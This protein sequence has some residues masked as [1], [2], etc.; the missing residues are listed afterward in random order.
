[1]WLM[2]PS[3]DEVASL[4]ASAS[5]CDI[6]APFRPPRHHVTHLRRGSYGVLFEPELVYIAG[7][8]D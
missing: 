7:L 6:T 1:M 3:E 8:V 5:V 2:R 4:E